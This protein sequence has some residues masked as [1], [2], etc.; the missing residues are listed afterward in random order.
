MVRRTLWEA[1]VDAA[2]TAATEVVNVVNVGRGGG[3]GGGGGGGGET[4]GDDTGT[5]EERTAVRA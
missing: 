2:I 5:L 3:R 4:V 1:D